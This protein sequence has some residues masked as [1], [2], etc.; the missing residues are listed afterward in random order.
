MMR[1]ILLLSM[2]VLAGCAHAPARVITVQVPVAVPC[3]PPPPVARPHLPLADLPPKSPPA[4]VM[5][6]YAASVEALTGY[7]SEL[8][9]LLNGYRA[10]APGKGIEHAR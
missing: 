1:S 10:P 2:V 4:D 3:P 5:R 6:A 8:E 7:A 9:A